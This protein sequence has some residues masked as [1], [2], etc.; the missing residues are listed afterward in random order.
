[1]LSNA[2]IAVGTFAGIPGDGK[3]TGSWPLGE[4]SG[5]GLP[6]AGAAV[7][8]AWGAA[9]ARTAGVPAAATKSAVKTKRAMALMER[10]IAPRQ[11]LFAGHASRLPCLNLSK[12]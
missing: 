9:C 10:L 3:M 8:A 5:F 11:F 4:L 1:M 12:N 6:G 7:A 2:F